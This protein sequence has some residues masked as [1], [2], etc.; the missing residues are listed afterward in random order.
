MEVVAPLGVD[1]VAACLARSDDGW[2]VEIAFGYED[3]IASEG[4][5]EHLHLR[6]QL[7]QKMNCRAVDE[8][9]DGIEAQAVDVI[10]AQPHERVV[11]EESADLIA[12]GVLEVDGIAPRRAVIAGAVGAEF[13]GVVADGAEVVIDHVEQH[14]E[15]AEMGGIDESLEP[16]GTAVELPHREEV[17]AVVA[18]AMVAG[19]L[20]NRHQLDVGDA[21]VDEVVQP[22]DGG[23]ERALGSEGSNVQLVDDAG[24]K[25][26][27]MPSSVSPGEWVVI[28]EARRAVDSIGLPRAA[29]IGVRSRVIVEKEG[30]VSSVGGLV[31]S[32]LPPAAIVG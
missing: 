16:V 5:R 25:R 1:A 17:D 26:R 28:V 7:L 27:S 4:R 31:H 32:G 18:P 29:R 6:G 11:T 15:A 12:A 9:V 30:I 2:V 10:V 21:E 14:G 8:S 22:I 24:G 20:G 13:A 23:L 19:E 3:E